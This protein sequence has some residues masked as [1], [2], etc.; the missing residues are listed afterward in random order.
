MID[1]RFWA[2]TEKFLL[3][4]LEPHGA[5]AV[6]LRVGADHD[7]EVRDVLPD[8]TRERLGKYLRMRRASDHIVVAADS[9][10]VHTAVLPVH[11]TRE[12]HREP[13]EAVELENLLSQGVARVFTACRAEAGRELGIDELEAVLVGSRVVSFR[14]DGHRVLNPVGFRP[15]RI[16]AVLELTLTTREAFARLKGLLHPHGRFFFI[17]RGRAV[18]SCLERISGLPVRY[19]SLVPPDARYFTMDRAAVGFTIRRGKIGWPS[20]ACIASIAADLGVGERVARDVYG[21]YVAGKLSVSAHRHFEKILRPCVAALFRDLRDARLKGDVHVDSAHPLPFALPKKD[22]ALTVQGMP[23]E[24]MLERAGV[25]R[26]S[27]P[28]AWSADTSF[29]RLAP[30]I[31]FYY[32][33][34]DSPVNVWLRRH[35]HWLGAA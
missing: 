35:L 25:E 17:E 29:V 33:R 12:N 32:H 2:K 10:L 8:P 28:S 13:L 18:L 3:L 31:E 22:G 14:V 26:V 11:L 20:D 16:E 15:K 7:L 9:A 21:A 23:F 1:F 6:F 30:F 5:T 24:K 27:V 4:E 19:V 34:D